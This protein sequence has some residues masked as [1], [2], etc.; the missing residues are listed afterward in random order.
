MKLSSSQTGFL[1]M[2]MDL[3]QIE[4]FGGAVGGAAEKAT[5]TI[6]TKTSEECFSHLGEFMSQ[7]IKAV[8][9]PR[10]HKRG[11]PNKMASDCIILV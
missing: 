6:W 2:I 3:F 8:L 1:N 9:K 10:E 11:I 7:K 5:I 4:R